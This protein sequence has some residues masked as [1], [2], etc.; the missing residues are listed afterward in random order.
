LVQLT[1]RKAA[2][3]L[4]GVLLILPTAVIAGLH[5]F[6]LARDHREEMERVPRNVADAARRLSAE[7][8]RRVRELL[9]RESARPFYV[10]RDTYFPVGTIGTEIAFVP[11]PL[12]RERP[13][14]ILAWFTHNTTQAGAVPDILG[15]DRASDDGRPELRQRLRQ[16]VLDMI[17]H[18]V[19]ESVWQSLTR[20]SHWHVDDLP[21]P[22]A[23]INLHAGDD[24]DCLW[25]EIAALRE[26]SFKTMRVNVSSFHVRFYREADGTPRIAVTRRVVID[27]NPSLH[28][29]PSCID[30]MRSGGTLVQG[31][32]LDPTWYFHDLPLDA[33]A[34]VLDPDHLFVPP[35]GRLPGRPQDLATASIRPV[36]VLG[37]ETYKDEDQAFGEMRVALST[38]DMEARFRR[39]SLRF[40][41]VAAMLF[42][43]LGTGLALLLRSVRRD[44]EQVGRTENF[45][46][47]V[48]HELRTPLAA[49]KLYGEML[50]DGWAEDPEKQQEYYRRIVR[51]TGRLELLVE[52]VLEKGKVTSDES[53]PQPGDL[54]RAVELAR[55]TLVQL[56][57]AHQDLAFDLAPDLP[58]VL[59][60]PDGVRSILTNLVENARK[61]APVAPNNEPILVRTRQHRSKVVLEVLDRGPGIPQAERTRIF[62]A[63]YRVGNETTRTA[64]GTGLG[65]HLVALQMRT[66]RGRIQV[67][68]REGGGTIFRL[69]LR[70]AEG[71]ETDYDVI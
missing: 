26:L 23:A 11:S 39:Q 60:I 6:Q 10:Y 19:H 24:V 61:Y 48:T 71:T 58:E 54:T 31:F 64:S 18:D 20:F 44:L 69:T 1:T 14:G 36:E 16:A 50:L 9:E 68:D 3:V 45:V 67:L 47:A 33:A 46:A 35:G 32:F 12:T 27:P 15:A 40:F 17:D 42:V 49:I 52:R 65:L 63:F 28:D 56:A 38:S 2:L 8:E 21:V 53:P 5:W 55:P 66:M 29:V 70:K 57:A 41:G 43:S 7:L 4:Y 13:D 30:T 22:T 37:C 59:L 34:A 62:E 51:E 25:Q